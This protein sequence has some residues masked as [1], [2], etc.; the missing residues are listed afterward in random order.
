MADMKF[1]SDE[2][3]FSKINNAIRRGD[4]V[5]VKGFPAKTKVGELS[6][7]PTEITLLAVCHYRLPTGQDGL[8]DPDIRYR[9]RYL[10]FIVNHEGRFPFF[11]RATIIQELR[12]ILNQKGFL[13]VETPI[14][15]NSI[16]GATANP[17]TSNSKIL[18]SDLYL[19][20]S[21]ELFLKQLIVGGFSRVYEIG[22]QF[23]N[24]GIDAD[25]NP[26][27]TT[28]EFYS[29]FDEFESLFSLTEEILSEMVKK[30]NNGNLK[31][32]TKFEENEITLD[33]TPPFKRISLVDEIERITGRPLPDLS[34][35]DSLPQLQKLL[36][37]QKIERPKPFTISRVIDKLVSHL[38]EPQCIQPTFVCHHPVALSPL[39]KQNQ[40]NPQV[41]D[42]FE[43][44]VMGKE[45]TNAYA[46]L[47][48]PLEQRTRFS[49][50]ALDRNKGEGEVPEKDEHFCKALEYG[51]APTIGWGMGLDRVCMIL[52][53][54]SH[55]RDVLLFP[56]MR[57]QTGGSSTGSGA[58]QQ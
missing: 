37:E 39:A 27:F 51:M 6:I 41:T 3:S 2:E 40:K 34:T 25:H 20:I 49:Q 24:E 18:H 16:G 10:D 28:C 19:R 22:K 14:L 8:K 56:L 58:G 48:D 13:E 9:E 17:F 11:V 38:I 44:F 5:G 55:I 4:I 47:N 15:S 54:S 32:Q 42:R 31:F 36:D 52:T 23:R 30:V 46:E 33:F 29:S 50:Q 7:V 1:Y 26:E 12:R 43:L 35:E 53:H 57:P 21:P 45:I